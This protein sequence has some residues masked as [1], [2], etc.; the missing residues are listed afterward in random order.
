L[1]WLSTSEFREAV[2]HL[3]AKQLMPTNLSS[4]EISQQLSAAMRRQS[5]FSATN[6]I[7]EILAAMKSAVQS[8]VNPQQVLRPGATQTVTEGFNP[9]SAR[10]AIAQYFQEL[11]Y[12]PDEGTEGTL[13]DLSSSKRI[14]LVVDTNVK[15]AHG[16]G[17]YVQQNADPDVVDLWPALNF[18]RFEER[19]EPRDWEQRWRLAASVAGDPRAAAALELHGQMAALKSSGIWQ[20]LGDGEGGY[21][22]TLGNPYPP[23]AFG[24]GM[25]TEELSREEAED[26]GL[27]EKG[28]DVEPADFDLASLF[29][30]AA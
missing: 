16:A 7:D 21:T 9:A 1:D 13:K 24:S 12:K 15:L 20:A 18:V 3:Q 23:F 11:G 29:K 4:A 5:F 26:L 2:K 30:E 19:A 10:A 6:T 27:L 28:Q 8:I 22:D 25:W 17:R 14:D